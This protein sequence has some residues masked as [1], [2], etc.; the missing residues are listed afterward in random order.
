M[1]AYVIQGK[2]MW[3]REFT[4]LKNHTADHKQLATL[5]SGNYSKI[6]RKS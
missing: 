5:V 6:N 3:L 4:S 2:K 1:W